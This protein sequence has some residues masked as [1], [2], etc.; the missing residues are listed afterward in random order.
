[1]RGGMIF[2]PCR[3]LQA[4]FGGVGASAGSSPHGCK[5]VWDA[6]GTLTRV[7]IIE[8]KKSSGSST[9]EDKKDA[10]CKL[11]TQLLSRE[12]GLNCLRA[13]TIHGDPKP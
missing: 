11:D 3:D 1:M 12:L 5:Q 9:E 8:E 13:G 10:E 6:T 7:Y 2:W 4:I